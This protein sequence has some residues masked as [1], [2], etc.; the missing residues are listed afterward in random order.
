MLREGGRAW[1]ILE[2]NTSAYHEWCENGADR[3]HGGVKIVRHRTV[4]SAVAGAVVC[5]GISSLAGDSDES[6]WREMARPGFG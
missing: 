2:S 4:R 1:G 5:R 6:F 3:S